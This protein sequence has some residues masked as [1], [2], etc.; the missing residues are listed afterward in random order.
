[1]KLG[2]VL[3]TISMMIGGCDGLV[4]GFPLAHSREMPITANIL[5]ASV[6]ARVQF[7]YPSLA[8]S[9]RYTASLN[10]GW[11]ACATVPASQAINTIDVPVMILSR[12]GCLQ[13][14]NLA[15]TGARMISFFAS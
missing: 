2:G 6:S 4:A 14:P 5:L 15:Q 13:A 11:P 9:S 3:V 10:W 7:T 8:L 1:M 12:F